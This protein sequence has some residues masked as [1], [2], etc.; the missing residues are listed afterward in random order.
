MSHRER[1]KGQ[2]DRKGS[3]DRSGGRGKVLEQPEGAEIVGIRRKRGK[4]GNIITR[5]G[6]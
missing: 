4:K 6:N 2:G 1:G 5:S 3:G